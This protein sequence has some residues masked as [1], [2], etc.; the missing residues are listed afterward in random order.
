[1]RSD[2]AGAFVGLCGMIVLVA[3]GRPSAPVPSG[4][5]SPLGASAQPATTPRGS[6]PAAAP[7]PHVAAPTVS[8][9]PGELSVGE[10]CPPARDAAADAHDAKEAESALVP[11]KAGLTLSYVW[12]GGADDY[13]HECLDQVVA[14][15]DSTIDITTSCPFGADHHTKTHKRRLCRGDLRDSYFYAT[16][17][18]DSLPPAQSPTTL[19][20]LSQ[21]SFHELKTTGKTRHRYIEISDDWR[22]NVQPMVRDYDGMLGSTRFDREPYPVIVNNRPVALPAVAALA[23][24][25]R[26]ERLTTA[27]ILDD[28][29]FPLVLD[30][31]IAEQ[32]FRVRYTKI[33]YPTSG[34]IEKHLAT[35]KRVDVYGIYFDFASDRLRPESAPILGEIADALSRN[36]DWTL[37]INGHTDNVGGDAANLDLSRR[38]ALAVKAALLNTYG[39]AAVRLTTGGFGAS[40]PQVGNDTPEGRARNRRVE[41]IRQ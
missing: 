1:M 16:K 10:E 25:S 17:D 2:Q 5:P 12:T 33:S 3:C 34:E 27:R 15:T 6:V 38:R 28:E 30:Y 14:V 24:V 37:S 18:S 23:N 35:E 8:H 13:D 40:Q 41:L 9:L 36:P 32:R 19:F 31:E 21:R 22:T 4:P 29:R 39:I 20:S 7:A 11:L 26:S